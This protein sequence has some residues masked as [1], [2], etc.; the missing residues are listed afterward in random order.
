MRLDVSG[1]SIAKADSHLLLLLSFIHW[2]W[3]KASRPSTLIHEFTESFEMSMTTTH[4]LVP[5][6][7]TLAFARRPI[8]WKLVVAAAIAAAAPDVDTVTKFIVHLPPMSIY[9]HRGAAHSLFVA[10]AAGLFASLFHRFLGVRPL[11]AGVVIAA[12]MASHG[13]IDMM[14]NAGL[15]VAY[16]WPLSSA[17]LWADWRPLQSAEVH[18]VHFIWNVLVRLRIEVV[19]III[20][21]FAAAVGIRGA[22]T[23]LSNYNRSRRD[24][25]SSE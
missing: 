16:L 14:T 8:P 22:R 19:Q 18:R 15:P 4:A 23:L 11:T 24:R 5:L 1:V 2:Q 20:P 13:I 12:S 25:F 3:R 7:A 21:M 9:S 6:A 17:R 10:L